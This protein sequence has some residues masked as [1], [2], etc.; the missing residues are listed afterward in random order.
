MRIER[1]LPVLLTGASSGIGRDLALALARRGCRVGLVARS[2]EAL[3]T[4][5]VECGELGGEGLALPADVRDEDAMAAAVDA[6]VARFGGL[7]LVVANAGL[8]R[9]AP[10]ESQPAEHVATTIEIN[11]VGMTR[12]VRLALPHLLAATPAHVVGITSSA[13]LIPHREGSA[14][15]ASKAASNQYLAALRLEVADRGVGVSW[16]CPGIV[17]T[18]FL[19]KAE[20]DP[21]RQLPR[22]NNLL[23]RRL[24]TDDVVHAT[25]RA[26]ERN[27]REVTLPLMMR[28]SA[29]SMRLAPTFSDW[30]MRR[31]G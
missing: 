1:G 31:T 26:I 28:L 27:R 17:E 23:I 11:Y 20:L 30:L 4:L 16:I 9:Y 3:E 18:P 10:V 21:S 5:A 7:R 12:T 2:R 8:G 13:G 22:L 6:A 19:A 24:T 14:Y 25:L 29:L 15:C